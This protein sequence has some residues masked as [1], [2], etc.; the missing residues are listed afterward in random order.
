VV[1]YKRGKKTN[2]DGRRK[3]VTTVKVRI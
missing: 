1:E 2:F 3:Y